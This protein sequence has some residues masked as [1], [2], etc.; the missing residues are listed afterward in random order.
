[1]GGGYGGGA[2]ATQQQQQQGPLTVTEEPKEVPAASEIAMSVA[3]LD[4]FAESIAEIGPQHAAA[5]AVASAAEEVTKVKAE[6]DSAAEGVP[7]PET[8]GQPALPP[9]PTGANTFLVPPLAMESPKRLARL[10]QAQRD[11]SQ[12]LMDRMTKLEDATRTQR[13]QL[14]QRL[15]E[16]I[17]KLQYRGEATSSREEVVAELRALASDASSLMPV[18]PF[19]TASSLLPHVETPA[20]GQEATRLSPRLSST[21]SILRPTQASSGSE[22]RSPTKGAPVR[23]RPSNPHRSP[24]ASRADERGAAAKLSINEAENC[25]E[26]RENTHT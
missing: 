4:G 5:V 26:N 21:P 25:V 6:A 11:S 1:M 19:G 23:S 10:R 9:D 12:L 14:Q 15:R 24:R 16:I 2:M 8:S 17:S 13:Q 3:I 20:F 22:A 7:R 18:P